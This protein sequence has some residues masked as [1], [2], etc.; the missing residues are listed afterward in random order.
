[1]WSFSGLYFLAFE[2]NTERQAVSL[3]FQFECEEIHTRK[4]R[5]TD[6]FYALL[7]VMKLFIV[8]KSSS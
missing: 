1:M 8:T 6:A 7:D 4:T 3:R 5:I 2:L